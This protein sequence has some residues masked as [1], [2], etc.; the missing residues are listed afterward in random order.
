MWMD[1]DHLKEIIPTDLLDPEFLGAAEA[2]ESNMK[3]VRTGPFPPEVRETIYRFFIAEIR[4]H[5]REVPIYLSTET[6]EMWDT[7]ED[8]IGQ[9]GSAFFCGCSP[10]APPGRRLQLSEDCP[11][12]TYGPLQG[13]GVSG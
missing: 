4:K 12:S 6:R 7:L 11:C 9:K 1:V 2:E 5:D 8:V 10:V 13:A 3:G